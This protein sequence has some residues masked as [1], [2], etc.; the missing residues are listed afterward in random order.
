MVTGFNPGFLWAMLHKNEEFY[1]V[2]SIPKGR[3]S[4]QIEVPKVSL[5]FLQSWIAYHFEKKWQPSEAVHGFVKT[6][7]HITARRN[8][9]APSGYSLLILPISFLQQQFKLYE[10]NCYFLAIAKKKALI[11]CQKYYASETDS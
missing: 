7:S 10:M 8:I 1:R 4:R 9:S 3:G 6:R 11:F 5:K 2:F